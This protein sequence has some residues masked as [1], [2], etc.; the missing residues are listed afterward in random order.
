[1]SKVSRL[2]AAKVLRFDAN[3]G[4][5]AEGAG[6]NVSVRSRL[7]SWPLERRSGRTSALPYSP[8]R[9][10]V[11]LPR[12]GSSRNIL[13]G[14]SRLL[15]TLASVFQLAISFGEDHVFQ[16]IELVGRRDVADG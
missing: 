3:P 10:I 15:P 14:L 11:I 4:A 7:R 8:S 1:M 6:P 5:D 9:S 13:S 2:R 16:S 12:Q